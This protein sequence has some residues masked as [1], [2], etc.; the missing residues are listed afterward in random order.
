MPNA[1]GILMMRELT[2]L[3]NA[4]T[5]VTIAPLGA[6]RGHAHHHHAVT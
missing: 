3:P 1:N 6:W 2:T 4:D 5:G